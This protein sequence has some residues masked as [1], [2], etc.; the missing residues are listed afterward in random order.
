MRVVTSQ[1]GLTRPSS[2]HFRLGIV[3]DV[4]PPIIS[5]IHHFLVSVNGEAPK[6]YDSSVM[7]CIIALTMSQMENKL[8][9]YF[10]FRLNTFR[11]S[12]FVY[13]TIMY[14]VIQLVSMK[15]VID[16][17]TC[18]FLLT[19]W[20][21]G[22]HC[23]PVVD[24]FSN[25]TYLFSFSLPRLVDWLTILSSWCRYKLLR[26]QFSSTHPTFAG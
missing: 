20:S 16:I 17:F 23:C 4:V 10:F 21:L 5:L 7:K 14:S 1:W 22:R 15:W 8:L 26:S 19:D 9:R 18:H 12:L 2:I 3:R 13:E 24:K 11:G 6:L 25:F